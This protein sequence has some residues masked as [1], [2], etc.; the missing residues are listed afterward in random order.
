MNSRDAANLMHDT[1]A[2]VARPDW[3]NSFVACD[4]AGKLWLFCYTG[5]YR[6]PFAPHSVDLRATDWYVVNDLPLL[7]T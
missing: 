3:N 1:G 2:K 4:E 7:G 5:R 6:I